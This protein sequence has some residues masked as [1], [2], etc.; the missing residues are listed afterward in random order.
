MP[1]HRGHQHAWFASRSPLQAHRAW[2]NQ[3][4]ASCTDGRD[5][6]SP[7][8]V[9]S[10]ARRTSPAGLDGDAAS[11]KVEVRTTTSRPTMASF[12]PCTAM[13][14]A[15]THTRTH[16][17]THGQASVHCGVV[18]AWGG[19]EGPAYS[20]NT[21]P[22]SHVNSKSTQDPASVRVADTVT[23]RA[24]LAPTLALSLALGP[25]PLTSSLP[26]PPPPPP[27]LPA[28]PCTASNRLYQVRNTSTAGARGATS[29]ACSGTGR[30]KARGRAV[31]GP[32]RSNLTDSNEPTTPALDR[33]C[34]RA[35][36]VDDLSIP[37]VRLPNFSMRGEDACQDG[38]MG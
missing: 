37:R 4:A 24:A 20:P 8:A 13:W 29:T 2:V 32:A 5:M 27:P 34:S 19:G 12:A 22:E 28:P 15:Q 33:R 11:A 14:P 30:C 7:R 18:R 21:G 16:A 9:T 38:P 17:H 6:Q 23:P 3:S 31:D 35:A 26:P 36:T 1:T 10:T 25:P